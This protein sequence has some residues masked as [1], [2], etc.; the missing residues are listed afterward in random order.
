MALLPNLPTTRDGSHPARSCPRPRRSGLAPTWQLEPLE[1]RLLLSIAPDGLPRWEDVLVRKE[2]SWLIAREFETPA[3]AVSSATTST[4]PTLVDQPAPLWQPP[5]HLVPAVAMS[6]GTTEAG[7]V[8]SGT[9][10]ALVE[11]PAPLTEFVLP[12]RPIDPALIAVSSGETGPVE[13]AG[14]TGGLVSSLTAVAAAVPTSGRPAVVFPGGVIW[15]KPGPMPPG[16]MS[17]ADEVGLAI[18]QGDP[19]NGP[20]DPGTTM[21]RP[22]P[23]MMLERFLMRHGDPG[24]TTGT[25]LLGS[26]DGNDVAS[27]GG[28]TSP[29]LFLGIFPG[30]GGMP[31]GK[32]PGPPLMVYEEADGRL[33][34]SE[35]GMQGGSMTF[36][37]RG[38]LG[39]E[40]AR[41]AA[42]T[43]LVSASPD[44]YGESVANGPSDNLL[45]LFAS[46]W[47]GG[48]REGSSAL[49]LL[50]LLEG[51]EVAQALP[52][53]GLAGAG[54]LDV[55]PG[56]SGTDPAVLVD[57][58]AWT[59]AGP[60]KAVVSARGI[61]DPEGLFLADDL[62][63][64]NALAAAL[65]GDLLGEAAALSAPVLGQFQEVAELGPLDE[66]SLAL[67][68]TVLTVSADVSAEPS[69]HGA[70][71][72]AAPR[73]AA[74][75][76]EVDADGEAG[77][78]SPSWAGFVM[79]L[80]E[81]FE[82]SRLAARRWAL[83]GASELAADPPHYTGEDADA[84]DRAVD[85]ALRQLDDQSVPSSLDD[86][87]YLLLPEV[88]DLAPPDDE[89]Q[90]AAA[91]GA[92]SIALSVAP[93][94]LAGTIAPPARRRRE[95]LPTALPDPGDDRE[96][97]D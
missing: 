92:G 55:G 36:S 1:D 75:A 32:P 64:L 61:L 28:S 93:A 3:I 17:T 68:A 69:T 10:S 53:A 31:P 23:P 63:E 41:F 95:R 73:P 60:W 33:S 90:P 20:F 9:E 58:D 40:F 50:S 48:P 12:P 7:T 16:P 74:D 35:W 22:F 24:T 83:P 49:A 15:Q 86:E 5:P 43:L 26:N 51:E 66:S 67:A 30:E 65:L 6:G 77:A 25:D 82:A 18:A 13:V 45:P 79:G 87:L 57:D 27:A 46:E 89:Q 71:G 84:A 88:D 52:G 72:A 2:Q 80:D 81:G 91:A 76:A 42:R 54:L 62:P 94:M 38:V 39:A 29:G 37:L 47:L 78:A 97:Q 14:A 8:G 96:P 85:E 19:G 56:T 11:G 70:G 44:P 21:G 34:F 59:A 4:T